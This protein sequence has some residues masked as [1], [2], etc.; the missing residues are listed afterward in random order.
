MN[1]RLITSLLL[2]ASLLFTFT[3]A[4]Q[5]PRYTL[6]LTTMPEGLCNEFSVL[7]GETNSYF[8]LD[9]QTLYSVPGS[10]SLPAGTKVR[11]RPQNNSFVVWGA[12]GYY[13]F[14][15]DITQVGGSDVEILITNDRNGNF[16]RADL[17]MPAHDVTLA[18]HFD[19]A[20]DA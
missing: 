16:D 8:N 11:L 14:R 18:E 3:A 13:R 7:N 9:G 10:I 20:P 1:R 4:A 12:G 15:G 5:E 17:V 6:T 2:T 19:Y